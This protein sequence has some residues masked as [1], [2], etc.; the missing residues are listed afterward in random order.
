VTGI[1]LLGD[2]VR[3]EVTGAPSCL[4]DITPAALADLGLERGTRVWLTAKATETIAY[5]A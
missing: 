5:P 2:R 4:V 1:E 3:V